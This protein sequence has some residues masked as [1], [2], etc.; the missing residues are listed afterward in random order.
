VGEAY[1]GDDD[2]ALLEIDTVVRTEIGPRITGE[3]ILALERPWQLARPATFDILRDRRLGLVACAALDTVS[4]P[5]SPRRL[6]RQ[7]GHARATRL[8]PRRTRTRQGRDRHDRQGDDDRA[9]A[10]VVCRALGDRRTQRGGGRQEAA[11][12]TPPPAT[13]H[14]Q[15]RAEPRALNSLFPPA[16]WA[17]KS[18]L[19]GGGGGSHAV[20][21]KISD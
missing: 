9:V 5:T 15:C 16:A 3:D 7:G 1:V 8:L 14:V 4:I 13:D 21:V 6:R 11:L 20:E 2:A 18:P 10:P 19:F 17:G 12:R